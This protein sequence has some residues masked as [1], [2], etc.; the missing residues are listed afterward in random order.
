MAESSKS[1]GPQHRSVKT[2]AQSHLN[3]KFV[4]NL[5]LKDFF[6]S[7]SQKRIVGVLRSLGIDRGVA[8]AISTIC[9]LNGCLPQGAPSSPVLSNMICF[10]LDKELLEFAKQA[11]CIYTRYADDLSFSSYQPLGSL[12]QTSPPSPGH[13]SPDLLGE[14]LRHIFTANGFILNPDKAHYADRHSR[15]TVTGIRINELLNVD[16]RFVRNLRAALYSVEAQ[17]IATAEAKFHASYNGKSDIGKH[18]QGKIAWLG[19]IKGASD[20]VFRGIASRFNKA[21]PS[22]KL[23]IQPTPQEIRERA[24]WLIEHWERTGDQGTAFFLEGVGLVTAEH[25]VSPSGIVELYHPSKPSNKF[26]ASVKHRCKHRDLAVLDH[27]IPG[28]EFY[29]FRAATRAVAVGNQTTAIGYPAF[30]PGDKLNVRP[31]LITSLPVKSAVNM[32]EVQQMLTQGMSGGP[33]LDID[34]QV[35]GV[36]HKGGPE[37]GRQLAIDIVV[38]RTWLHV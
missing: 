33:L 26:T 2:N 4:V 15:R 6:P 28:N 9:C 23:E 31:G 1:C 25:C 35:I 5:D 10:R 8:D 16:R 12:F 18:L 24:V 36:V 37:Y 27:A 38:L 19:Y 30:G 22:L 14:K 21:F 32:I 29:E 7:I 3:S 20:P 11:K 17:G 13:F 34:D